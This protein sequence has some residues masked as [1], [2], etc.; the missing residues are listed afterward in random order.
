MLIRRFPHRL[1]YRAVSAVS[2]FLTFVVS[3]PDYR[4]PV[5]NLLESG[6]FEGRVDGSQGSTCPISELTTMKVWDLLP[7]LVSLLV[8][9]CVLTPQGYLH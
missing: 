9:S 6:H 7:E 5:G 1:L 3:A 8:S 2:R 4:I